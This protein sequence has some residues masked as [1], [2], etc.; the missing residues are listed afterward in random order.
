MKKIQINNIIDNRGVLT[1]IELA[2]GVPFTVRRIYTISDVPKNT[3]RGHHAHLELEQVVFC[4]AGSFDLE[5]ENCQMK[6]T[7]Q[8]DKKRHGIYIGPST[9]RVL[10]N[11]SV[12]AVCI[13][14]ASKEYDSLDY[15]RDYN[16]F[17]SKFIE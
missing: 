13:V 15:I 3:T 7:F 16:E 6:R 10:K 4:A 14:L 9:W 5:L 1:Y 8:L 17:K 12:D 11:F 2:K